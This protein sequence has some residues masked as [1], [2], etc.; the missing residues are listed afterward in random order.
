[1]SRSGTGLFH[2]LPAHLFE[3]TRTLKGG[4]IPARSFVLY[5]MRTAVR[6]HENPALDVAIEC[7]NMLGLPVF[8]YQGLSERYPYA[9]DRHHRFIIEGA[10]E[11][12]R[13]LADRGI[14]YAFHLERPG[15]KGPYLKQ[16]GSTACLV[17][18]EDMPTPPLRRWTEALCAAIDTPVWCVDT[19]CVLPMSMSRHL[20]ERAFR[21]REELSELREERTGRPWMDAQP[22][23]GPFVPALP[24]HPLELRSE[25]IPRLVA[26]CRI[27]HSVAPVSHSP[28]GQAEG[29]R[30][31]SHF[32]DRLLH[33]YHL[34][35]GRPERQG[36]SRL[37]AYLHYG[38]VS[39][40]RVAREAAAFD[41]DGA[42]KFLD[43]LLVWREMAYHWCSMVRAPGWDSLPRWAKRELQ[44]EQA[45][46]RP[47][48]YGWEELRRAETE[49]PLWNQCQRSLLLHGELH[50]SLRMVWGKMFLQWTE[51]PQT[52]LRWMTDLNNRFALDGRDPVSYG[53][54]LWC[55]GLFDRPFQPPG[56]VYGT[57]RRMDTSELA[58]RF[59]TDGFEKLLRRP[60]TPG[61]SVCVIGG[62]IAGLACARVLSDHRARAVVFEKEAGIGGRL[63]PRGWDSG[64]PFA[65]CTDRRFELQLRA[66]ENLGAASRWEPRS[67]IFRNGRLHGDPDPGELWVGMPG[68][69]GM[70]RS[71]GRGLE[72]RAGTEIDRIVRTRGEW[73]LYAAGEEA[74]RCGELVL[75]LPPGSAADLV[76]E[77][78]QPGFL[79]DCAEE[80]HSCFS[81]MVSFDESLGL[82]FDLIRF[83]DSVL[84][85]AVRES[86]KPRRTG[87]E[88]WVLQTGSFWSRKRMD[89]DGDMAGREAVDRFLGLLGLDAR[90]LSI[91]TKPW[92]LAVRSESEGRPA[93]RNR[94]H[95][96]SICGDWMLGRT[97]QDAYLSGV[98]AAALLLS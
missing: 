91:E 47:A 74:G 93:W 48:L 89:L 22:E 70:A 34:D 30:R 66:W 26:A 29:Y 25:D 46:R 21:F 52:A 76:P 73:R 64:S 13:E 16:L 2:R 69:E 24:F 7:A 68:M 65:S 56:P 55:L 84:E 41:S 28:G 18:T 11:V 79:A 37:S 85:R 38:H 40:L 36:T 17:V 90:V 87:E 39:P 27:D 9:S 54:L 67:A 1:M 45:V 94:K 8:V 32:R 31:W 53:S 83:D 98:A 82:G 23:R 6:G 88:S 33:R 50:G 75:A 86:A 51:G 42:R 5:W 19:A 49:D 61:P 14:G 57:V 20:P 96:L 12:Q 71:L 10:M 62:G 15:M 3:R 77:T 95:G 92:R 72:I 80:F 97:V 44:R 43:E 58:R 35:R 59:D 60:S 81:V 78:L 4:D 63:G